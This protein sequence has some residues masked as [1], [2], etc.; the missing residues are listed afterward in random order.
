[1]RGYIGDGPTP[2]ADRRV[3][4]VSPSTLKPSPTGSSSSTSQAEVDGEATPEQLAVLEAD[5]VAWRAALLALRRDAEEH[6]ASARTAARRGARAGHRRPRVGA[7]P[8]RGG[9][10]PAH[11]TSRS[12]PK[13][14]PR[15]CEPARRRRAAAA[16]R[17]AT[18]RRAVA[19]RR[20]RS[21]LQV[22]W[23]P[24]RVVA[25][26]AGGG[27]RSV[28]GDG[29]PRCS[30]PRARRPRAGP[31]TKRCR[32]PAA[33]APTRWRSRS[34]TCSAGWSRPAPI[35]S[36]TTSGRACAGS[37]RVAIWAVEL[38]AHGAMVPLLRQR[39]RSSGSA[40]ESNGSYSVRWTPALID[41]GAAR[42][43]GRE[44]ARRRV[45]VRSQASTPAR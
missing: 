4:V 17:T 20:P 6:L 16:R 37:G 26:A 42:A 9:V 3:R 33:R 13:P 31:V 32:C 41:A 12:A 43:S 18:E 8:A 25:W 7:A 2:V 19:T 22:S 15:P 1:M 35:R 40:R 27:E 44:H 38:T 28:D 10:G 39:K 36:A 30:P 21:Q 23:E 45:R 11:R 14:A 5:R 24:G 34:A 29:S